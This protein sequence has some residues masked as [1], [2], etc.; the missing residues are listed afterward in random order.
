MVWSFKFSTNNWTAKANMQYA[1][2]NTC[3]PS[4]A[5]YCDMITRE[6]GEKEIVTLQGGRVE[7]Y[8]I[9]SNTWRDGMGGFVRSLRCFILD[10]YA[11]HTFNFQE[12]LSQSQQL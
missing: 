1:T 11:M 12:P 3:T 5:T 10:I 7:I 8:N 4:H 2:C 9:A 6:E